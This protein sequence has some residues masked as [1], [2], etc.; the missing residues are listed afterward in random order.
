VGASVGYG[1]NLAETQLTMGT[2]IA[3]L[4]AIPRGIIGSAGAGFDI[5][6]SEYVVMGIFADAGIANLKAKGAVTAGSL[7]VVTFGN[8]TNYL[9]AAGARIGYLVSP[10]NLVY[11]K[12]GMGFGGAKPDLSAVGTDKSVSDTS[13]GWMVGG[14]IEHRVG[15]NW[16]I[17]AES[18]YT[19]LGDQPL[20]IDLGKGPVATSSNKF[21]IMKA[22]AGIRLRLN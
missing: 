10:A 21:E 16:S 4:G 5:Q 7:P 22:E 17:F 12:G 2:S 8:A 6:V 15:A 1:A 3:D 18:S 13:I 20:V 9:G 11:I 14:G 19:R